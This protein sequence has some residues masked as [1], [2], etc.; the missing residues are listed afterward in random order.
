MLFKHLRAEIVGGEGIILITFHLY[1]VKR[2]IN[3]LMRCSQ[4]VRGNGNA[5]TVD[6]EIK[7]YR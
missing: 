1:T 3:G 5:S 2:Y 7:I 4:I 6:I